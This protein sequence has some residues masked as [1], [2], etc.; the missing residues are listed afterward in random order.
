MHATVKAESGCFA[1]ELFFGIMAFEDLSFRN[2]LP[3]DIVV[4]NTVEIFKSS[5]EE[6]WATVFPG[7][8]ELP[9]RFTYLIKTR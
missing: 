8:S 7:A 9:T 3:A 4:T 2:S 1:A 5:P 6:N